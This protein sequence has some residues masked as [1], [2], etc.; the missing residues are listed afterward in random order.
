MKCP[1]CNAVYRPVPTQSCRRCGTDLSDLIQLHDRALWHYQ[2]AIQSFT[3]GDYPQ[4]LTQ[5][6]QALALHSQNADFHAFAGQLLAL[7]GQWG[8]AI[9][10]WNQ[11]QSLDPQHPTAQTYL[12]LLDQIRAAS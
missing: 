7:Q 6:Q 11:A 1:V 2:Q 3:A 12:H 4:A 5:N 8:G 10:A 9:A